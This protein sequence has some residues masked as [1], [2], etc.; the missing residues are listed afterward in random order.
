MKRV[1]GKIITFMF[2]KKVRKLPKVQIQ[3]TTYNS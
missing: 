3:V 2:Y 1:I